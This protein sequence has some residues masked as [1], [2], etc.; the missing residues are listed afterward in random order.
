[1]LNRVG[2]D[3]VLR[4]LDGV[5]ESTPGGFYVAGQQEYLIRGVGRVASLEALGAHG[6]GRSGKACRSLLDDV[7]TVRL[8]E[9]TRRGEA[10][11][12]GKHAVVLKVQKQP[13]GEHP[14]ADGARGSGRST[15]CEHVVASGPVPVSKRLPPGGFHRAWR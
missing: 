1:M 2:T 3:Q 11:V 4:A 14:R 7:A 12:D 6:R 13:R 15:S 5:T 10:A 9:A 8:G